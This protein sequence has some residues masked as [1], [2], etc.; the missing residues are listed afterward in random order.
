V[1]SIWNDLGEEDLARIQQLNTKI[2]YWEHKDLDTYLLMARALIELLMGYCIKTPDKREMYQEVAVVTSYNMASMSWSGW[3][4]EGITVTDEHKILGLQAAELNVLIAREL[5]LPPQ[6]RQNG[7]WMLAAQQLANGKIQA[8]R[9]TFIEQLTVIEMA[10]LSE[11]SLPKAWIA[12]CNIMDSSGSEADLD[13]AL[14]ELGVDDEGR[15]QVGYLKTAMK[16]FV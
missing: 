13:A 2:H 8:A 1:E 14:S 3:D 9:E 6:R 4:E 10:Q 12:A 5:N 11:G 16:V 15:A 7:L